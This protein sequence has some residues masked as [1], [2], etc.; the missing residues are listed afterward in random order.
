M[1]APE[2]TLPRATFAKL[3]PHPYLLA[4]LSPPT[5]VSIP[6][7]RSN[8]RS[9]TQTR[10]PNVN[11]SSLTHAHGSAVVRTG[12]T[13][14]ICGVRGETILTADIPNYNP[15]NHTS[16]LRDYD[17]L[18]PNIEL[19]TGSAP[20]FLPGV[21]PTDLAQTLSTRVYA[22]LHTSK[23]VDANDLR[24]WRADTT[25]ERNRGGRGDEGDDEEMGDRDGGNGEGEE[26]EAEDMIV[27][28][29]WVL[30]IDIF[31]ISYDGNPF[32]TAWSALLGALRDTKLP[33]AAWDL[34]RELIVCSRTVKSPLAIHGLPIACSASVFTA[35]KDAEGSGNGG[36]S[37]SV[38]G[39]FWVLVDPDR[40]E[41]ELCDENITVVVDCGDNGEEGA[42]TKILGIA[43]HGGCVLSPT[44]IREFIGIAEARWREFRAVM[45]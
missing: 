36:G 23:L 43:K 16:E 19:A 40:A 6:A 29:Y 7:A 1:A 15:G 4:N 45:K 17:L 32:D 31:F 10:P 24:I 18:V 42:K 5:Q 9:P 26:Q 14:V 21:P 27:I 12:D 39:K 44:T 13:T 38:S 8:G 33:Q 28:G 41:E 25:A 3:S 22:L 11:T 2:N 20:Q 34:D 37:G 35:A 30:Y